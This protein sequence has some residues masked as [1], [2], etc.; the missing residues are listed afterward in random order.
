MMIGLLGNLFGGGI[1][2]KI[3]D[4]V[5]GYFKD[6]A[7]ARET[8]ASIDARIKLAKVNR[9]SKLELADHEIQVLRT[10]ASGDSWKDEFVTLL[11]SVPIIVSMAGALV[12]I[13]NVEIGARLL[14]SAQKITAIMTGNTIDYAELWLIVVATALG[15]KPLRRR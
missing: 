7:K 10:K 13:V 12:E 15:T 11:V 2:G 8:L 14:E 1:I 3:V 5:S 9:D 6:Q 4:G